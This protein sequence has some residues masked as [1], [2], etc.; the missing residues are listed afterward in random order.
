MFQLPCPSSLN[1]IRM[2]LVAAASYS[3]SLKKGGLL[4]LWLLPLGGRRTKR[5][6]QTPLRSTIRTNRA[7]SPRN[8]HGAS[9]PLVGF[10]RTASRH[11]AVLDDRSF[12]ETGKT[13]Q[14]IERTRGGKRQSAHEIA[15]CRR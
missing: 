13:S 4:K 2:F 6:I 15:T 14:A 3:N 5:K 12:C 7:V 1:T 9:H 11:H 8:T 10:R